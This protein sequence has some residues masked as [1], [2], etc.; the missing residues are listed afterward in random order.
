MPTTTA[1]ETVPQHN[2]RKL[3]EPVTGVFTWLVPFDGK[4]GRLVIST[5]T[6]AAVYTVTAIRSAGGAHFGGQIAGYG[7]V[8]EGNG[9]SY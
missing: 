3:P 8:N 5:H 9:E 6:G 2:S 4:A 1:R 7:L